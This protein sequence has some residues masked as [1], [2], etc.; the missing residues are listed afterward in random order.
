MTGR[1]KYAAARADIGKYGQADKLSL[2]SLPSLSASYSIMAV[3]ISDPIVPR[4]VSFRIQGNMRCQ[5]VRGF[6]SEGQ[7]RIP[8]RTAMPVDLP[9]LPRSQ[10][11]PGV[12]LKTAF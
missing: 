2:P 7:A 1:V 9:V 5:R 8:E 11:L 12:C 3:I 6:N 10:L 4:R